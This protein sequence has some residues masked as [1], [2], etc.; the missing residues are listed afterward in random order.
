MT[1]DL[2]VYQIISQNI[3]VCTQ[4]ADFHCDL[5][6]QACSKSVNGLIK[7]ITQLYTGKVISI[8]SKNYFRNVSNQFF[9]YPYKP[10][11]ENTSHTT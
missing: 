7:K 3:C 1:N 9:I 10:P 11:Q 6:K 5:Y 2:D 8:V 4:Y